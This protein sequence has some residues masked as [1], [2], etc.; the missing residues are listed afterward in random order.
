MANTVV[1]A[2]IPVA[3]M[4]RA[5]AFYAAILEAEIPLM[6]GS[7]GNVALLPGE[8]GE[9]SADLAKSDDFTPSSQGTRI[10][11]DCKGDIDGMLARVV[12]A[13]GHIEMPPTDMGEVVGTVA[14]F[15]DSEGNR[16]GLHKPPRM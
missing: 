15:L 10:Y 2:D 7:E 11:L 14:F 3:D 9:V 4:E 8:M 6:E 12:G 16:L 13:G 1:W 5:R